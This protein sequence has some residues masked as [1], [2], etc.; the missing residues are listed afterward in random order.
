MSD[1]HGELYERHA[2]MVTAEEL[3]LLKE[4]EPGVAFRVV[5]SEEAGLSQGRQSRVSV[6]EYEAGG[7]LLHV[8]W[9]RMGVGKGLDTD[10]ASHMEAR[11]QPY[12][13]SLMDAGWHVPKV[14]YSRVSSLP[15]EQQIF[16]YEQFIAGG[17]G[18]KL[19]QNADEPNFRKWFL[20]SE[21]LRTL[22]DYPEDGLRRVNLVGQDVTLLPHGL[23]LKLANV[24]LEAGSN[25][26]YFV[27]LFGPKELDS[28]SQ[29]LTYSTKLDRLP[30]EQ[31]MAV[32]ATREGAILRCW[33]LAEQHWHN[34]FSSPDELRAE[35]LTRLDQIG[36]PEAE[37]RF[38]QAEVTAGYPWLDAIYRETD[39]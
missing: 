16:S 2:E 17:D 23:D 3:Q 15:S 1:L 22:R 36:L 8:L 39:V 4:H 11:L 30:P 34:G 7:E 21:V 13:Q 37:L 38:I 19:L 26:L 28:N 35:F 25:E 14:L 24:V 27:D 12:R 20:V 32:T 5:S 18:E 31:L 6:L 9:K 29:W 33:R 10:E